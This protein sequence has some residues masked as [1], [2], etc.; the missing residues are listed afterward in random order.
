M[1]F[2]AVGGDI[3]FRGD[4]SPKGGS[5]E[6]AYVYGG[7]LALTLAA[8]L[9][10]GMVGSFMSLFKSVPEGEVAAARASILKALSDPGPDEALGRE[11]TARQETAAPDQADAVLTV[12]VVHAGLEGRGGMDPDLGV[13]L[14]LAYELSARQPPRTLRKGSLGY[15]NKKA[16]RKFLEWG[17]DDA[18]L[19]REE[20]ALAYPALA[21]SVL[22]AAFTP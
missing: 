17:K 2:N 5:S 15:E 14:T 13:S 22:Q 6:G 8:S 3:W 7:I 20:L 10:G 11:L 1:G 16:L 18:R 4:P 9:T 12:A 21:E 19:L